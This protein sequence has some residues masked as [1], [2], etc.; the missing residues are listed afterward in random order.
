M[1]KAGTIHTLRYGTKIRIGSVLGAGGEG[2]V[3]DA[4][5]VDSGL[6]GAYKVIKNSSPDKVKRT[7]FLTDLRLGD[8]SELLCAPS[9]YQD[10]GHL[11]HFSP[12]APGTSLEQHLETPGNLYFETYKLAIAFCFAHALLNERGIAQGDPS[13]TNANVNATAT[14]PELHLF[15]FDNFHAAGAPPPTAFGQEDRMAP[16]LR[17][18]LHGGPPAFPDERSDRY[19]IT[20]VVHDMLL[21]KSVAAGFDN[22]PEEFE[23]AMAGGWPHDPVRGVHPPD[24]GGYPSAILNPELAGM[25]R[26]GLSSNRHERPSAREWTQVLSKHFRMIWVDTR[27]Q[28]PSFIDPGK[29][30]CPICGRPF[31]SFKLVFPSLRKTIVCDSAAVAIGRA[32][33]QSPKVSAFHAVIRKL[34]PETRLQSY[35]RNG[36]F[37]WNGNQWKPLEGDALLQNHDRLRLADIEGVVE[38]VI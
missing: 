24:S 32:D 38:E 10:N 28:G 3:H 34:G 21:T 25:F 23:Q 14:G 36:T 19:A 11:G 13:L 29:T 30:H 31:P 22:T 6:P 9:D 17:R 7:Q 20:T 4:V 12:W 37:R 18:A 33:L 35:G 15:D 26:R 27:C 16:E 5:E 1:I 8:T 2:V